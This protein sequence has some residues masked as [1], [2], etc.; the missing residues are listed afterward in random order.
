MEWVPSGS[1]SDPFSIKSSITTSSLFIYQNRHK[2]Y[3]VLY[4]REDTR[5]G[6][7]SVWTFCLSSVPMPENKY[8]RAICWWWSVQRRVDLRHQLHVSLQLWAFSPHRAR[9]FV[10]VFVS[11][12]LLCTL[13]SCFCNEWTLQ[14]GCSPPSLA[15]GQDRAAEL[16][17][18]VIV[19]SFTRCR[20]RWG[21][22]SVVSV[23]RG[24][25]RDA[26]AKYWCGRV[27]RIHFGTSL[28]RAV[29]PSGADESFP[30]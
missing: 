22:R 4:T 1:H 25:P 15:P 29:C 13:L 2:Y 7:M 18:A 21:L 20:S 5:T 23:S 17:T 30:N 12:H 8:L 19:F 3:Y 24:A 26:A 28:N 9:T 11:L 27:L 16:T 10:C 6:D 14:P